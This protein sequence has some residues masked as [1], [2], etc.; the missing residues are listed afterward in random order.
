MSYSQ[1]Q[2]NHF[3]LI[4]KTYHW[5]ESPPSTKTGAFLHVIG[6]QKSANLSESQNIGGNKQYVWNTPNQDYWKTWEV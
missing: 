5:N 4:I 6:L 1:H 2:I 3:T